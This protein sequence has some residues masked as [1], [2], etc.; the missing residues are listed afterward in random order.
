[1][2]RLLGLKIMSRSSKLGV[3]HNY[4]RSSGTHKLSVG[5]PLVG[6]LILLLRTN[7]RDSNDFDQNRV[8][9]KP[10][11]RVDLHQQLRLN[12]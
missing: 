5:V 10:H 3:G 2:D 12:S 1:M 9:P 8:D 11:S 6:T 4:H 7:D